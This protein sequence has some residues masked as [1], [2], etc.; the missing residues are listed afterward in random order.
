MKIYVCYFQS[1][2]EGFKSPQKAF[3]NKKDA[4]AWVEANFDEENEAKFK[5]I[6]IEGHSLEFTQSITEMG[7]KIL[8]ETLNKLK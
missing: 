5:D 1:Y 7:R 6:D 2:T 4:E 8:E 3:W